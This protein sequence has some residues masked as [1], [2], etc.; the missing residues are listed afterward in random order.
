VRI[1]PF[2]F[3][4]SFRLQTKLTTRVGPESRGQFDLQRAEIAPEKKL[5][6]DPALKRAAMTLKDS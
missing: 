3:S 5:D 4:D 6:H 2:F 1:G